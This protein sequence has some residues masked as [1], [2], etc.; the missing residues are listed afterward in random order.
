VLMNI[1]Y[2]LIQTSYHVVAQF[3]ACGRGVT[4]NKFPKGIGVMASA[5][6]S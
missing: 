2:R 4:E 6:C 1:Q 3:I 5:L